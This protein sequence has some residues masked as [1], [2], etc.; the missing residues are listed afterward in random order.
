ML[1]SNLFF[2]KKQ[3]SFSLNHRFIGKEVNHFG[4]HSRVWLVKIFTKQQQ[5][6]SINI[7]RVKRTD[8]FLFASRHTGGEIPLFM[9]IV[10]A[11]CII[12]FENNQCYLSLMITTCTFFFFNAICFD[13]SNFESVT[14]IRECVAICLVYSC[15]C[16][17]QIS[18][19]FGKISW[20]IWF[21]LLFR[22][23]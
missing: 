7:D 19:Q 17:R 16:T 9:N 13:R 4:A 22:P 21:S 23:I 1:F 20:N 6:T 2:T 3:V 8:T 11:V 14:S 5:K 15:R 12:C 18:Y 10:R